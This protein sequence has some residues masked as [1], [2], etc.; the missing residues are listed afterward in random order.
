VLDVTSSRATP[1]TAPMSFVAFAARG[2]DVRHVIVGGRELMRDGVV[3]TLDEA[4]A[5]AAVTATT[6][7]ILARLAP[8]P[9][10]S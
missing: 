3:G 2:D 6:E 1:L 10:G 8:G 7:R 4:A 9:A 5:R